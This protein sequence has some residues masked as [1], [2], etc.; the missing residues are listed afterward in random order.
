VT[1]AR[2]KNT[3]QPAA[4]DASN[5]RWRRTKRSGRFILGR[6]VRP[7]ESAAARPQANQLA[8]EPPDPEPLDVDAAGF[9]SLLVLDELDEADEPDGP[10]DELEVDP[11]LE[12]LSV[13]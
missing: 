6:Y 1:A 13:R 12:R 2:A 11:E 4:S 3:A 5:R 7:P 10:L 8:D 9:D